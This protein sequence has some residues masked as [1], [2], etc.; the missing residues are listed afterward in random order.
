MNGIATISG[1]SVWGA[2]TDISG[3]VTIAA[4]G[5]LTLEGGSRFDEVN[6]LEGGTINGAGALG[7][8]NVQALH[9]NGSIG[10][11]STSTATRSYL[12]PAA[13]SRSTAT[14]WM[15]GSSAPR[16]PARFST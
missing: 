12:P 10:P 11:T 13:H 6:R 14:S 3:T 7:A 4:G 8:G 5:R 2:R 9:G 15:R 1:N 16:T